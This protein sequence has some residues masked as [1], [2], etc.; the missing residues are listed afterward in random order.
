MAFR[1][2]SCKASGHELT[3]TSS[4]SLAIRLTPSSLHLY[5]WGEP[6]AY[7]AQR[8]RKHTQSW[9]PVAC[10][11]HTLDE[12]TGSRHSITS[13]ACSDGGP[14]RSTGPIRGNN[15]P[16]APVRGCHGASSSS[17]QTSAVRSTG[18]VRQGPLYDHHVL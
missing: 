14:S 5:F 11:A 3:R 10:R 6:R 15:K 12:Q 2:S 1:A 8:G 7:K 4:L 13:G 18:N 16:T 9:L 17:G